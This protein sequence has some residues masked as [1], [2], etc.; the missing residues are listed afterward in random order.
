MSAAA[1]VVRPG[2]VI[3]AAAECRDGFPDHGDFRAE[4]AA[5][6]TVDGLLAGIAARTVTVPDQWQVQVLARVLSTATV[7]LYTTGL[8]PADVAAAHLVPVPD[9]ATFVADALAAAEAAH[10]RPATLCVLP[11]GPQTIPYVTQDG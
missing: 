1:T 11:E 4:L 10:G 6:P 9:V 2:G 3:V 8:P 5:A 7:G